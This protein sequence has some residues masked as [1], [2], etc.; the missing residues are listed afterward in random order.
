MASAAGSIIAT[1][2]A[3]MFPTLNPAEV[4]RLRHFGEPRS[5]AASERLVSSGVVSPGMFV[6]LKGAVAVTQ[7]GVFG[8]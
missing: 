2:Y 8:L 5:Y 6:I 4:E 7:R 1:R 3:Q